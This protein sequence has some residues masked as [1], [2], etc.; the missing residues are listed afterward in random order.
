MFRIA[1]LVV[2]ITFYIQTNK[3]NLIICTYI[4]VKKYSSNNNNN[5]DVS[6]CCYQHRILSIYSILSSD[7]SRV[8]CTILLNIGACT[9]CATSPPP[10]LVPRGR[11]AYTNLKAYSGPFNT[12]YGVNSYFF[13]SEATRACCCDTRRWFCHYQVYKSSFPDAENAS[14]W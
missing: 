1:S 13:N 3:F 10:T 8:F 12:K 7:T 5:N 4:S 9:R 14:R 6:W 11:D 2:E